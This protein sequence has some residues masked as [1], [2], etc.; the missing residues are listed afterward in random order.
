[1]QTDN[2][3]GKRRHGLRGV[4]FRVALLVVAGA[5]VVFLDGCYYMQAARGQYDV[6]RRREP[7]SEVIERTDTDDELRQRLKMV[8]EAREFAVDV[9]LLPDNDSYRS[10]ADLER[11]YVVWNVFAAPEFSLSP[12]TWCYPVAGCVAYRGYFK[13]SAAQRKAVQLQKDGFDVAVG[14]V[15][16][17]STLGRFADP[18]LNTMLRWPDAE[19]IAT[20]FHELAHQQLYVKDDTQFNESFATAVAEIGLQSWL[21][22]RGAGQNLDDYHQRKQLRRSLVALA[23]GA[24]RELEEL[25]SSAADEASMRARKSQILQRLASD[26]E[27]LVERAGRRSANWL[28][29]PLNNARLVSIGLY[30]GHVAAFMHMYEDC[31]RDLG[32]FYAAADRLARLDRD[33]REQQLD[34]MS[35]LFGTRHR[36][37]VEGADR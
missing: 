13:E 30:E 16:A 31:D 20:L 35:A 19:L 26:A 3:P 8:A 27:A 22:A 14:G 36:P 5:I 18:L 23:E 2:L 24:K 6:M 12:R 34:S 4:L 25:Y 7:L 1:M 11:D 10:Y 33:E 9:L 32:C 28:Q 21:D 37:V 29:P 17:Y 15:P